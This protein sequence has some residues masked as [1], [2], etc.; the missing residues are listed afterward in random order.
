MSN[1]E[2]AAPPV[3]SHVGVQ[4]CCE[5]IE[6][7]V[8]AVQPQ[9]LRV[10]VAG[11]G[12]GHEAAFLQRRLQAEVVAVDVALH[13]AEE[14]LR[15]PD[16]EWIEASVE[17][18]PLKTSCFHVVFYHHV[19]EH[20]ENP[21]ESL[22]ELARVLR[23]DGWMF[24]GTPNRRRLLSAL[25]AHQQCDWRPTLWTKVRENLK[26]WSARLRGRF[27]N[28][29]GAHAGF[30]TRELD[31]MLSAHFPIRRWLT[32]DYL[33]YKYRHG[34]RGRLARLVAAGPWVELLA[35]SI[36]V[37]C[38]KAPASSPTLCSLCGAASEE[39]SQVTAEQEPVQ[40]P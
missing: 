30:S 16:L 36:Y 10:L 21:A 39:H 31:C 37:L 18:L 15:W 40:V 35:P 33:R 26:D 19:I 17:Q 11:C 8:A 4:F 38:G 29:L 28:E 20:V 1:V 6:P 12:A 14:F 9:K 25:G 23:P 22:C 13:P 5:V 3:T 2:P 7:L 32:R 34:L 24:L 27:R